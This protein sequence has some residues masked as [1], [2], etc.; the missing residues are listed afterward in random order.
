[1]TSHISVCIALQLHDNDYKLLDEYFGQEKDEPLISQK[2]QVGLAA[3]AV[4]DCNDTM[5]DICNRFAQI[6]DAARENI[7]VEQAKY[8]AAHDAMV[9]PAVFKVRLLSMAMCE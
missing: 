8:K 2:Q 4:S 1:M 6:R 3:S 9:T 5:P 7:K